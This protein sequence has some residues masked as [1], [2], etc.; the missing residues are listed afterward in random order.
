MSLRRGGR[1]AAANTTGRS[2]L[3]Q[4]VE[5]ERGLLERIGS[6]GDDD[7]RELRF[8]AE[9]LV[10]ALCDTELQLRCHA[11]APDGQVVL[12]AQL[13]DA[14]QLRVELSDLGRGQRA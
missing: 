8:I 6:M 9:E 13:G 5:E 4:E 10:D 14:A 3:Q 1:I 7:S 2:Q 12:H 11:R